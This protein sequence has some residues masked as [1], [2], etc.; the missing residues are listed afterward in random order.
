MQY[1]CNNLSSYFIA[2]E[3]HARLDEG[4][5]NGWSLLSHLFTDP[6]YISYVMVN[7]SVVW[8]KFMEVACTITSKS[9]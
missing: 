7:F 4:N 1:P 9:S 8:F 5:T 6:S 3:M 2:L